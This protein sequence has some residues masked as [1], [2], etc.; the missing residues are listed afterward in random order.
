MEEKGGRRR[1][2]KGEG[3][4]NGEGEIKGEGEE[5]GRRRSGKVY[6]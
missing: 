5:K 1:G 3:E 4:E 2:K 6:H